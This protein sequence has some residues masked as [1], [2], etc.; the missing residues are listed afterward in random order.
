MEKFPGS[1][2]GNFH[3]GAFVRLK[4][5]TVCFPCVLEKLYPAGGPDRSVMDTV[6]GK[7]RRSKKGM[8]F[9]LAVFSVRPFDRK[10]RRIFVLLREPYGLTDFSL[11][12]YWGLYYNGKLYQNGILC[13]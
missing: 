12:K 9:P 4:Q 1:K 10:G 13:L 3:P 11:D 7:I 5:R 6:F 8:G 2:A